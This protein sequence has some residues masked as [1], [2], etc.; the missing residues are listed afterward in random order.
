MKIELPK[1]ITREET[2]KLFNMLFG[3]V[4]KFSLEKKTLT[5]DNPTEQM[6]CDAQAIIDVLKREM[7]LPVVDE[8]AAHREELVSRLRKFTDGS[9]ISMNMKDIRDAVADMAEWVGM[10][11]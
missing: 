2:K 11:L 3:V 9:E 10:K 8:E 6:E 4:P 1:E 5:I 7:G